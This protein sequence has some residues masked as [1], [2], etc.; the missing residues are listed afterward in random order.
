MKEILVVDD[1]ESAR[2]LIKI[3]IEDE[4]FEIH[5]AKDGTEAL[6]KARELKPDLVI[7]D[8][9]MPDKWGYEVCEELRKEPETKDALILFLTARGSMPS[10]KMGE[11][12]GGDEYMVKPFK[13]KE[14]K[15]AVK[16]LLGME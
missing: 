13:P 5:E 16:K 8:L 1:E 15:Q 7:L 2:K 12:K 9:M 14:L 3:S 6:A 10:K 4:A 11:I